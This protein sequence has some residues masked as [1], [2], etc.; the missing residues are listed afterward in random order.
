VTALKTANPTR[1][2]SASFSV[3]S[4]SKTICYD[5]DV[6]VVVII[7]NVMLSGWF[8]TFVRPRPGKF[9]FYKTRARYN[10]G[11]GPAVEK[12]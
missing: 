1:F 7:I 10:S 3:K 5:G 11:H 8:S 12:H 9:F 2:V 4:F 6:V